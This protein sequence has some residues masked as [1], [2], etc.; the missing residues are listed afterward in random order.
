MTSRLGR[1]AFALCVLLGATARSRRKRQSCR[2]YDAEH[3]NNL[4]AYNGC[5]HEQRIARLK[6]ATWIERVA[7]IDE[8][9]RYGQ[10]EGTIDIGGSAA[11]GRAMGA[12][13]SMNARAQERRGQSLIDMLVT[14]KCVEWQER[15]SEKLGEPLRPRSWTEWLR[16]VDAFRGCLQFRTDRPARLARP[17][18]ALNCQPPCGFEVS[19]AEARAKWVDR[20]TMTG[21]KVQSSRCSRL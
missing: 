14:L 5:M 2:R 8:G 21:V 20:R 1:S 9:V 4:L 15:V 3:E 16:V 17:L 12:D 7:N 6:V 18:V 10:E 11:E 19:M 13:C